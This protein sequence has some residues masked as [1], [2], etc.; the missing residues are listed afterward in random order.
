MDTIAVVNNGAGLHSQTSTPKLIRW[1]KDNN[2]PVQVM[3]PSWATHVIDCDTY[4]GIVLSGSD[5]RLADKMP[6]NDA[7]QLMEKLLLCNKPI[8][9]ICYGHQLL[10][11]LGGV[12]VVALPARR[13]GEVTVTTKVP[14]L[15]VPKQGTYKRFHS[16]AVT[17]VPP[18]WAALAVGRD[19]VVEAMKHQEKDWWGVQFHPELSGD[20]GSQ[21]LKNFVRITR[22][23]SE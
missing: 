4:S 14:D 1:F 5:L 22:T 12:E 23:R 7:V 13:S 20:Q 15:V 10:A 8:L 21:L 18:G 2:I 19:G 6:E 17:A 3:D 9:G 16:D 11:H